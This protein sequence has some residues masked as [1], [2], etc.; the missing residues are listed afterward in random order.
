[1]P[2]PTH[3]TRLLALLAASA[4]ALVL[5]L[6]P[7]A[8]HAQ[9]GA[10][11]ITG[12]VTDSSGAA[13]PGVTV[14]A[15]NQATNVAYTA[16]SNP[17][18]NYT[19]TSVPVGAYVVKSELSGFKTSTTKVIALEA[20]QIARVDFRLE[21]GALE[22]TVEVG[23]EAPVLQTETATVGEVLS[24][25]TVESLPLNGRNASQL[26]LLLPGSL[27]PNP[28]GQTDTTNRGSGARPY[29]NG[30]REQ[31]NNFMVDGVEINDTMDNRIGYQPRSVSRPTTTRRTSA[32]W[33][34]GSSATSSS[35]AP[36]SST[37]TSSSS[38]G[39]ATSTPTPGSAI[40]PAP[41]GPSAS[42][43][44][45]ERPWAGPSRRTRSSSS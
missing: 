45:S 41:R 30:N 29:V 14:S 8:A 4:L 25:K 21:I 1:M 33:R 43:T 13:A 22:D 44:S 27:T 19:I 31:T 3:S 11:S 7:K 28:G 12:V 20:K 17:T 37:G 10:A 9:T 40:A 6:V 24:G 32:T 42:S 35:R 34:A 36:T 39:M 5:G 15:V 2:T 16:V 26:S 38:T 18:G 23:S